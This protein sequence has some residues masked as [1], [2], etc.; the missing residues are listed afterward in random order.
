MRRDDHPGA[1][2]HAGDRHGVELGD[3]G[4]G[5]SGHQEEPLEQEPRDLRAPPDRRLDRPEPRVGR[6]REGRRLRRGQAATREAPR[7]P[8]GAGPRRGERSPAPRGV[9]GAPSVPSPARCSLIPV[10]PAWPRS[11]PAPWRGRASAARRA[12]PSAPAGRTARSRLRPRGVSE[13]LRRSSSAG[14]CA[15]ACG[16]AACVSSRRR[17]A[18][19]RA[20]A[21]IETSPAIQ[22]KSLRTSCILGSF[23]RRR[24]RV[25][26]GAGRAGAR[27]YPSRASCHAARRRFPGAAHPGGAD[28]DRRKERGN[29]VT[30]YEILLL[31][32]PD[33]PE[34][35]QGEVVDT[36]THADRAGRRHRRAPRRVGPAEARLPDPEEGGGR[37]PP[38]Q[39]HVGGRDPRRAVAR[40]Q[41]RRR[42]PS[43]PGDTSA[44]GGSRRASSGGRRH[45]RR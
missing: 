23:A 27:C 7:P 33:L 3:G 40:P 6:R 44:G 8:R 4:D 28:S 2:H 19:T 29:A 43:S 15:T 9:R 38:R 16:S 17:R 1:D 45:R 41:D 34:E 21:A 26:R 10:R 22:P 32:D 30:E 11:P 25:T 37:L 20:S 14:S 5:R 35:K 31:L 24:S 12:S 42:R 13:S 36:G 39:L 18:S